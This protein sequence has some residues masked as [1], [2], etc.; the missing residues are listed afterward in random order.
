[1]IGDNSCIITNTIIEGQNFKGELDKF[2]NGLEFINH[3]TSYEIKPKVIYRIGARMGKPEGSKLREMK[4]AIHVM[5]PLGFNISSQRKVE[6]ALLNNELVEVGIR[7]DEEDEEETLKGVVNGKNTKFLRIDKVR[8]PLLELYI[9]AKKIANCH[10]SLPI[11]GVKGLTSAEKLPEHLVK[12][13]LR[14]QNDISVFRDGTI[15]Y[16]M[17]DI[18]MTHFK[19]KEIGLSLKK[20]S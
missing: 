17:V 7:Y 18:T 11:K 6:D 10:K 13:I 12:G 8:S 16:D 4:P 9:E 1:M 5:F 3:L 14:Y 19:P 15:R 2:K 20:A